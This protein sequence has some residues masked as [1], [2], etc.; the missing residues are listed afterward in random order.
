MNEHIQ[1]KVDWNRDEKDDI[2][3]RTRSILA[4]TDN[5]LRQKRTKSSS[6]E[7]IARPTKAVSFSKY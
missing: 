7:K 2:N 3:L 5:W 6:E 4:S 1:P